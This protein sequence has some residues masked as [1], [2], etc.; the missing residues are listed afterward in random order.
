MAIRDIVASMGKSMVGKNEYDSNWI[1]GAIDTVKNDGA[2]A[3]TNPEF[4]HMVEEAM[5]LCSEE[6]DKL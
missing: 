6:L 2:E 1:R 5:L 3:T 4:W